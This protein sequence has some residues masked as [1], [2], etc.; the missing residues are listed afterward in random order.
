FPR[1]PALYR[2]DFNPRV[3]DNEKVIFLRSVDRNTLGTHLTQI[4]SNPTIH[5]GRLDLEPLIPHPYP[6][7][8]VSRGIE[9]VGKDP[10]CRRRLELH[11][12]AV[13][14]LRQSAVLLDPG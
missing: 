7:W 11:G 5:L 10:S 8:E 12:L 3:A 2:H 14:L 13:C 1:H 6:G 9:L 4:H